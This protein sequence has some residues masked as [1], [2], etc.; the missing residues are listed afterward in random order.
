MDRLGFAHTALASLSC[1]RS[2]DPRPF[3]KLSRIRHESFTLRATPAA[4]LPR[5]CRLECPGRPN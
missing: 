3:T 1:F 5:A 2:P 4:I